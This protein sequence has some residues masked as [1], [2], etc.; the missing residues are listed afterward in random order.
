MNA[1]VAQAEVRNDVGADTFGGGGGERH[2]GSFGKEIAQGGKLAIFG[3]EIV[4]PFADAMRFVD[5]DKGG[6]P[7]FEIVEEARKHEAFGGDVEELE[8][9]VVEAAEAFFRF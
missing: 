8:R 3:A 7:F 6:I 5:G 1:G 9:I 2:E 4:A